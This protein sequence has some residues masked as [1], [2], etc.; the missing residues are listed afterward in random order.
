MNTLIIIFGLGILY[1]IACRRKYEW[2]IKSILKNKTISKSVIHLC[3]YRQN[4]YN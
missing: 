4:F 1:F 2:G 3:G